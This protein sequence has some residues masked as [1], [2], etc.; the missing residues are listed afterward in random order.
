MDAQLDILEVRHAL[1]I[2]YYNGLHR[3]LVTLT[4]G[5]ALEYIHF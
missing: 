2:L 3:H 1:V 5:V 4:R